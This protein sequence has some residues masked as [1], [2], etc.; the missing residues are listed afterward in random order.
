[1]D[2][3]TVFELDGNRLIVELHQKS[4]R[5][6]LVNGRPEDIRPQTYTGR[7]SQDMERSCLEE[8][9]V[10]YELHIGR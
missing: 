9:Y 6:M 3:G 5:A 7:F 10:P 4:T 8:G 2:N 1:M